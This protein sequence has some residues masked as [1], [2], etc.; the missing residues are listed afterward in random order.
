MFDQLLSGALLTTAHVLAPGSFE[1][2]DRRLPDV[3]CEYQVCVAMSKKTS[4]SQT[5]LPD[6]SLPP[7]AATMPALPAGINTKLPSRVGL[8]SE[9]RV[10]TLTQVCPVEVNCEY[11]RLP[12]ALG[13]GRTGFPS[14]S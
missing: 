6:G 9:F 3:F 10:V 2:P 7:S 4:G 1:V 11:M 13:G 12:F 8:T 5:P 14:A